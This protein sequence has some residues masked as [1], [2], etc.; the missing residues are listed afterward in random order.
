[1]LTALPFLVGGAMVGLNYKYFA[2][3]IETAAGNHLLLYAFMSVLCGHLMIRR[4]VQMP[5]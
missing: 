3:M 2:P 5:V 4:I 1:V